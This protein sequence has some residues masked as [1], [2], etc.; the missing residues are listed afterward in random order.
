MQA[1]SP[2]D[3]YDPTGATRLA[4]ELIITPNSMIKNS[5]DKRV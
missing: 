3:F 1:F 5:Q 4:A 2:L